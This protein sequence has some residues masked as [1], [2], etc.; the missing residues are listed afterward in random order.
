MTN[1]G[2]TYN[3]SSGSSSEDKNDKTFI[4]MDIPCAILNGGEPSSLKIPMLK[5]SC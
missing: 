5:G 2:E 3:S 4:E 1:L